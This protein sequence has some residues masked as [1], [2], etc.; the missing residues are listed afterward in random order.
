MTRLRMHVSYT[1]S[2]RAMLDEYFLPSV[3]A[4]LETITTRFEQ[5]CPSG[6][7]HTEGWVKAVSRKL[8]VILAAIDDGQ[9]R[10]D[11]FFIF[12]DCDIQFFGDVAADLTA[13]MRGLDFLAI[14][15]GEFCTGFMVIRCD[16]RA[17]F[18]WR[19][20]AEALPRFPGDQSTTNDFLKR[21]HKALARARFIPPPLQP[22]KWR[23]HTAA[24]PI[25][26]GLM[27]RVEYFNY[28]HLGLEDRVW[29]GH[30]PIQIPPDMLARMRMVHA[31]WTKGVDNKLRLL[32][33][34]RRL[35]QPTPV[36]A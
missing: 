9:K 5:E 34:V 35:K 36:H 23:E 10:G 28:M 27:P 4:T 24:G 18:M 26:A 11:E 31:N 29:D 22:A 12:S 3:P 32:E 2:H 6:E 13:R 25:R 16:D 1:E 19:E 21:H 17:K 30:R 20:V 14:D 15:D 7:Y 33:E 8:E